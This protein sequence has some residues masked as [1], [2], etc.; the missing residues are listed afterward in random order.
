MVDVRHDDR[1]PPFVAGSL[2]WTSRADDWLRSGSAVGAA[3]YDRGDVQC[4]ARTSGHRRRGGAWELRDDV[5]VRRVG[6]T[7]CVARGRAL[8]ASG[9]VGRLDAMV[10]TTD[11]VDP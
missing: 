8:S 6:T 9:T 10:Q 1:H 3:S 4:C 7:L 5:G 2:L 11:R